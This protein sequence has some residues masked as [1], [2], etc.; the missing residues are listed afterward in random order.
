MGSWAPALLS[1]R[2]D[3]QLL[4]K[5]KASKLIYILEWKI[6]IFLVELNLVMREIIN[7]KFSFCVKKLYKIDSFPVQ[8]A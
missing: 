2:S 8:I 5:V 4:L 3:A 7:T 1:I 6:Q